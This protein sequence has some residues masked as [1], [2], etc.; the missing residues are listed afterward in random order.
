MSKPKTK[1]MS[2]FMALIFIA[3]LMAGCTG[4]STNGEKEPSPTNEGLLQAKTPKAAILITRKVSGKSYT[5]N[6]SI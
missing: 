1:I 6:S 4:S 3:S 2:L 5:R